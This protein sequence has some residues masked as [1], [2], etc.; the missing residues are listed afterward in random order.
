MSGNWR[1]QYDAHATNESDQY[2]KMP[3]DQLI[4]K[5][6]SG[7]LGDYRVIW[8]ALGERAALKDVGWDLYDFLCSEHEYLDRYNCA[9]ALL[10]LM[11]SQAFEPVDISAKRGDNLGNNLKKLKIMLEEKI[12]PRK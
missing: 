12:G 9:R 8:S 4:K 11:N 7:K 6:K 1:D 10:K 5:F 2:M 3:L